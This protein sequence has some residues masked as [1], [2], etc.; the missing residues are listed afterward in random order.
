[1][2]FYPKFLLLF[3][4]SFV[5]KGLQSRLTSQT[6]RQSLVV[7]P[8]SKLASPEVHQTDTVKIVFFMFILVDCKFIMQLYI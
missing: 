1:M 7:E 3:S 6:C 8:L 4:V 5:H 2:P